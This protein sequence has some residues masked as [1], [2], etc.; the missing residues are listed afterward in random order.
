MDA[1]TND[2]ETVGAQQLTS[3]LNTSRRFAGAVP[4]WRAAR[5][6]ALLL[7]AELSLLV[8]RSHPAEQASVV[9]NWGR[10]RGGGL[11]RRRRARAQLEG[12]L[13][14]ERGDAGQGRSITALSGK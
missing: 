8:L 10:A 13:S 6:C 4:A 2:N 11:H 12:R 5:S 7:E 1:H 14:A 9:G 3:R